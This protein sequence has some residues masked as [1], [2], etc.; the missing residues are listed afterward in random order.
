MS[1]TGFGCCGSCRSGAA[2][3]GSGRI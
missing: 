1:P 3:V 2:T